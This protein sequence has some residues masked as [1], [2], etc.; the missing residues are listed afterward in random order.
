MFFID[1]RVLIF[2]SLSLSLSQHH[3]HTITRVAR[4]RRGK[5]KRGEKVGRIQRWKETW[6]HGTNI[7]R[8]KKGLVAWYEVPPLCIRPT[9]CTCSWRLRDRTF[10]NI[11]SIHRRQIFNTW[12]HLEAIEQKMATC[13]QDAVDQ[14]RR[15]DSSAVAEMAGSM[16]VARVLERGARALPVLLSLRRCW[17]HKTGGRVAASG[18]ED[19]EGGGYYNDGSYCGAGEEDFGRE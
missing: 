1:A 10:R 12:V 8:W 19:C 15:E 13:C 17:S 5:K 14:R 18:F 4:T 2:F 6:I 7:Q 9:F 11:D 3:P 16:G